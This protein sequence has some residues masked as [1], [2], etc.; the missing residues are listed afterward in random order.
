MRTAALKR[1][2]RSVP[3][4]ISR[5]GL[6]SSFRKDMAS[7]AAARERRALGPPRFA[8]VKIFSPPM[9]DVCSV[10]KCHR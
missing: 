5:T 6:T 8:F 2:L 9:L 7:A 4:P 10:F 1:R 3:K